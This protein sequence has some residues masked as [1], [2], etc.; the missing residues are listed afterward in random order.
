MGE[1]EKMLIAR[2]VKPTAQRVVIA[3]YLLQTHDHP[4][5]DEILQAVAERLPV[6]SRA[7]VYN[8][9]HTLVEAGV[10]QEVITDAGC[11]RYDANTSDHHH[12][13]DVTS[14]RIFDIPN[15]MVP[16]LKERLGERFKVHGYKVVFYGEVQGN[17][18]ITEE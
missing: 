18:A 14:G 3:E 5:A 6:L 4:T 8:T 10:I 2:G 17:P 1:V 11:V 9:L 12:F 16:E 7:T 13:V 15:D